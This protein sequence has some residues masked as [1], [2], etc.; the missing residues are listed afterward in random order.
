[1]DVVWHCVSRS[2][3]SLTPNDDE[4]IALLGNSLGSQIRKRII[5]SL[6]NQNKAGGK[7]FALLI[8]PGGDVLKM[9]SYKKLLEENYFI[10]LTMNPILPNFGITL[11]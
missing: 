10:P 7:E 2:N 6:F 8:L 4:T 1:M 5:L 3:I 9:N 11:S